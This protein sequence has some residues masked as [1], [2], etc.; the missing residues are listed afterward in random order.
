MSNDYEEYISRVGGYNP[1]RASNDLGVNLQGHGF[2]PACNEE[3]ET[4]TST[5]TFSARRRK[6]LSDFRAVVS[7]KWQDLQP[8]LK[9]RSLHRSSSTLYQ[10]KLDYLFFEIRRPIS[11]E[12]PYK[13]SPTS[14]D[15][16]MSPSEASNSSPSVQWPSS[17]QYG[18]S[19]TRRES[20]VIPEEVEMARMVIIPTVQAGTYNQTSTSPAEL[21]RNSKYAEGWSTSDSANASSRRATVYNIQSVLSRYGVSV[22]LLSLK[23]TGIGLKTCSSDRGIQRLR[24]FIGCVEVEDQTNSVPLYLSTMVKG[25]DTTLFWRWLKVSREVHRLRSSLYSYSDGMNHIMNEL[26]DREGTKHRCGRLNPKS[27]ILKNSLYHIDYSKIDFDYKLS[28]EYQEERF[29]ELKTQNSYI[30]K[31][32]LRVENYLESVMEYNRAS[33]IHVQSSHL[34]SYMGLPCLMTASIDFDECQRGR[35]VVAFSSTMVNISWEIMDELLGLCTRVAEKASQIPA[36]FN[37]HTGCTSEAVNLDTTINVAQSNINVLCDSAWFGY[38][39]FVDYMWYKLLRDSFNV[40]DAASVSCSRACSI[41]ETAEMRSSIYMAG[42]DRPYSQRGVISHSSVTGSISSLG[43]ETVLTPIK[44]LLDKRRDHHHRI[45]SKDSFVTYGKSGSMDH[46]QGTFNSHLMWSF[47]SSIIKETYRRSY[48]IT[49]IYMHLSG[50]GTIF[51]SV[52]ACERDTTPAPDF[53][54]IE[55]PS[56]LHRTSHT[57]SPNTHI[58]DGYPPLRLYMRACGSN[59]FASFSKS[60]NNCVLAPCGYI[61]PQHP[62][63]VTLTEEHKRQQ[64]DFMKYISSRR[65]RDLKLYGLLESSKHTLYDLQEPVDSR[66][67]EPF[68]ME[69]CASVLNPD[70]GLINLVALPQSVCFTLQLQ[71]VKIS[72]SCIDVLSLYSVLGIVN[73]C[74]DMQCSDEFVDDFM[75]ARSVGS[76]IAPESVHDHLSQNKIIYDNNSTGEEYYSC[77]QSAS[78]SDWVSV[79][80]SNNG[81]DQYEINCFPERKYPLMKKPVRRQMSSIQIGFLEKLLSQVSIGIKINCNLLYIEVS[82]NAT[83]DL[84][85]IFSLTLEDLG[86]YLWANGPSSL[87]SPDDPHPVDVSYSTI[88]DNNKPA[89]NESPRLSSVYTTD[90]DNRI[91]LCIAG[92]HSMLSQCCSTDE[93]HKCPIKRT[94]RLRPSDSKSQGSLPF[95]SSK[96]FS[97]DQPL[98]RFESHLSITVDVCRDLRREML[99]EPV[100]ICLRG[101][102]ATLSAKTLTNISTSWI[103]TNISLNGAQCVFSFLKYISEMARL[104]TVLVEESDLDYKALQ[105]A[106]ACQNDK[107]LIRSVVPMN[108]IKHQPQLH[109]VAE[110]PPSL[111]LLNHKLPIWEIPAAVEFRLQNNLLHRTR[112]LDVHAC[113]LEAVR[114]LGLLKL[115]G[116][117]ERGAIFVGDDVTPLNHSSGGDSTTNGE[118]SRESYSELVNSLGQPIALCL[119]IDPAFDR[120]EENEWR[121]IEDGGRCELP[122]GH[123]GIILPFVVRIQLNN[124]IYEIPSSMLNLTQ[125]D[126]MMF[127]LDVSRNYQ[128]GRN[129][130]RMAFLR[131]MRQERL[132]V[133]MYR[134]GVSMGCTRFAVDDPNGSKDSCRGIQRRQSIKGWGHRVVKKFKKLGRTGAIPLHLFDHDELKYAYV[135]VR[136]QPRV[137]GTVATGASVANR[138]TIQLSSTL[139]ISNHSHENLV[140]FPSVS[141]DNDN[142]L[143]PSS[144][145]VWLSQHSPF[146]S[147]Y[148]LS[149]KTVECNKAIDVVKAVG[150]NIFK[151]FTSIQENKH[152]MK[153]LLPA[154]VVSPNKL[155]DDISSRNHDFRLQH[156]VLNELSYKNQRISIP[157]SWTIEPEC[158]ICVCLQEDFP[159]DLESDDTSVEVNRGEH[160]AFEFMSEIHPYFT[161]DVL[162]SSRSA[163]HLYQSF[164]LPRVKTPVPDYIARVS[165]GHL[166]PHDIFASDFNTGFVQDI[167]TSRKTRDAFRARS[168]SSARMVKSTSHSMS[169]GSISNDSQRLSLPNSISLTSDTGVMMSRLGSGVVPAGS[170][171]GDTAV[172][173]DSADVVTEGEPELM[174]N[175]LELPLGALTHEMIDEAALNNGVSPAFVVR[176][177]TFARLS[178][179]TDK[180]DSSPSTGLVLKSRIRV[181]HTASMFGDRSED[182]M[183]R[184][185]TSLDVPDLEDRLPKSILSATLIEVTSSSRSR[186]GTKLG[187]SGIRHF[188]IALESCHVIENM[189]PFDVHILSPATYDYLNRYKPSEGLLIED[190]PLYPISIKACSR[191]RFSWYMKNG[192]F[193]LKELLSR[194]FNLKAP[195]D[196]V[197]VSRLVFDWMQPNFHDA[198][199]SLLDNNPASPHERT[200][201]GSLPRSL[202]V[203]VEIS[204]KPTD[205]FSERDS[206]SKRYLASTQYIYTIFVDKWIVNWLDYPISLC[207]GDGRYK[208]TI[209]AQNCS[210]VSQDLSSTSLQLAIRK[211]TMRHIPNF[212]SYPK[213][214]RRRLF[215]FDRSGENHVMSN[216]FSLPDLAFSTCDFADTA[217]CPKLHYLISTSVAPAPFF[218]TSVLEILPQTTV[219]NQF[220]HPLWLRE[221]DINAPANS[222]KPQFGYGWY[223][224]E[225]GATLEL[226]SQGKGDLIVEVTGIDPS[227]SSDISSQQHNQSSPLFNVWSSGINLKPSNMIQFR[228]PVSISSNSNPTQMVPRPTRRIAPGLPQTVQ[229]GL[230]EA[231]IRMH[232]GAKVVRFMKPSLADWIVLN[233]TGLD[234][235]VEQQGVQGYGEVVPT[236]GYASGAISERYAGVG[237]HFAC[238]DPGKEQKLVCKFHVGPKAFKQLIGQLG[239]GNRRKNDSVNI[240]RRSE[241]SESLMNTLMLKNVLSHR[242]GRAV[243]VKGSLKINLSRVESMRFSAVFQLRY[244]NTVISMRLTA[245]TCVAFG[246]KTLHF[247]AVRIPTKGFL[248]LNRIQPLQWLQIYAAIKDKLTATH[249]MNYNMIS[250]HPFKRLTSAVRKAVP[251]SLCSGTLCAALKPSNMIKCMKRVL[252]GEERKSFET[253]SRPSSRSRQALSRKASFNWDYVFQVNVL[254]LGVAICG[255]I[256]EELLYISSALIKFRL[257]L[258]NDE[259]LFNLSMGWIQSDVHDPAT[260][261][262]TM[263]RPLATWQSPARTYDLKQRVQKRGIHGVAH[264]PS[265]DPQA[266]R[267]VITITFNTRGNEYFSVRE[268]TNCRIELEPLSL[269]L[270]TR[271]GQSILLLVDEFMSI[272]GFSNATTEYFTSA[273]VG[274]FSHMDSWLR[275]FDVAEYPLKEVAQS[276]FS[277]SLNSG[278]RYNI[279]NLHV[280]RIALAINIRRS[281]SRFSS[282]MQA[283]NVMIRH[284]MH[285]VRRTPHIS[286]A[287]IILAQESLLELCCTPYALLS[288]FVI[289]YITQSVQ[290]MYKVLGAVDLIGNPKI[291]VHHW[292]NGICQAASIMRESLQYLHLPP[293]AIFLWFRS[294]SRI[295]V[296]AVSGI[297]DALYR[298]TG[299]WYLMFNTLALNSDR[300]AVLLMQ[301]TFGKSVDQPSNVM[302]GI[303][304]GGQ[305]IGRNLYVSVGNFALKPIHQLLRFFGS[306]KTAGGVNGEVLLSGVHI[307]GSILSSLASLTFGTVSSLLSGVSVLTQG[308]LH[309]IHSVPML[310]AIRPQRSVNLL[311]ASGPNRYNFLESWSMSAINRVS[312]LNELLVLL[313]LDG[314]LKMFDPVQAATSHWSALS[315]HMSMISPIAVCTPSSALTTYLWVNRTHVGLIHRRRVRWSCESK[316]IRSIEIIR[317]PAMKYQSQ[318][319][320]HYDDSIEVEMSAK[321]VRKYFAQDTFYLRL[322]HLAPDSAPP[323]RRL[324]GSVPSALLHRLKDESTFPSDDRGLA[325]VQ[326]TATTPLH[327]DAGADLHEEPARDDDRRG[328][329]VNRFYESHL[330]ADL[331]AITIDKYERHVD[332]LPTRGS[333]IKS[334][335]ISPRSESNHSQPQEVDDKATVRTLSVESNSGQ[336]GAIQGEPVH[337]NMTA[338][339]VRL[340]SMETAQ[341]YFTLLISVLRESAL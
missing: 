232:R 324:R 198:L 25:G 175:N 123:Y 127:R 26:M 227:T 159:L 309:Q 208:Q 166:G 204:R 307:L 304:F 182:S 49:P 283:Q 212:D 258:D 57:I 181:E 251:K 263:L 201:E 10:L 4:A 260:C 329:L 113:I 32:Y 300:Y 51:I 125:E 228:F 80:S 106:A 43:G 276:Q 311:Q 323:S 241:A 65:K 298:L 317:V 86:C 155:T 185:K 192:R 8:I 194:E 77:V 209:P 3:T 320:I 214:A 173:Q 37:T 99:L 21:R 53:I 17:A 107:D 70:Q 66:F 146:T 217:E 203:S 134:F 140:V 96:M 286:D 189:M 12:L 19:P 137:G 67:I 35:C 115:E 310:S 135:M 101:S 44:S 245:Q 24:A 139:W 136:T 316:W 42:T 73:G 333:V 36:A 314:K 124:C 259:H 39:N 337:T 196:T 55:R 183:H 282:D 162:L 213:R 268:I 56:G 59:I 28:H 321:A 172:S 68:R 121:V 272:F 163:R 325:K 72:L 119:Y 176:S 295:G 273:N 48:M 279:S 1:S 54:Q 180:N 257:S 102:K 82:S 188:E 306:V 170:S 296:S 90:I 305:S 262:A 177:R 133:K 117:Q 168:I 230:C 319:T 110:H 174:S 254:G 61:S 274:I 108:I 63:S 64:Y 318:E 100:V 267:N 129:M 13:H 338:E 15:D 6:Y 255:D 195:T 75:D 246:Q 210:L 288:H 20:L 112:Y 327:E 11:L 206:L 233:T 221:P 315:N 151:Q 164:E 157:L 299:S 50:R 184:S 341:L 248:R 331:A 218:R 236:V 240:S 126:E 271:I 5:P 215:S 91:S 71:T 94:K 197:D 211:T 242:A 60:F 128:R 33:D 160:K 224:L 330:T 326:V 335:L 303:V 179:I 297:A 30:S 332:E 250:K 269:N 74:M 285:I 52:R 29:F 178:T 78:E 18:R 165:L 45:S 46:Q 199:T 294:V 145:L 105:P 154:H 171:D 256:T 7:Q 293:V 290:Q 202:V 266:E 31:A 191:S 138:F 220:N 205:P 95:D 312:A 193:V 187:R 237:V 328:T 153:H 253:L 281:G 148:P 16:E 144:S 38:R 234:L 83:N 76:S 247:T 229:Y 89:V 93:N 207:R 280:G 114:S 277:N 9:Q 291:V 336:R 186:F 302:D 200:H 289:R 265:H 284:L 222:N 88:L 85:N 261:Y 122:V 132:G 27:K 149:N 103:N 287:N 87:P 2:N 69:L 111:G 243:R 275:N 249:D 131:T 79:A 14:S 340:P 130:N 109:K 161:G 169:R 264:D 308:L 334:P 98:V 120:S 156:I 41:A 84:S 190:V 23:V 147:A 81:N 244:G 150:N 252:G 22:P 238:Y 216:T 92:A 235:W 118:R 231:E 223:I 142:R 339:V 322:I 141:M 301:D 58:L 47:V 104:R 34:S 219:T 116:D 40:V 225:P 152:P 167:N 62:K 158:T 313:P 226:H 278:T 143:I 97:S 270:D 292:I 239:K